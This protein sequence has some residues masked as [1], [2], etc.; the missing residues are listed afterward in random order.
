MDNGVPPTDKRSGTRAP[1]AA[2]SRAAQPA[3][4]RH[5][6]AGAKRAGGRAGAAKA[7]TSA[8]GSSSTTGNGSAGR[9][10]S[11]RGAG[12]KASSTARTRT[13]S[14]TASEPTHADAAVVLAD[15]PTLEA[16][17]MPLL[18]P[19]IVPAQPGEVAAAEQ[20][21]ESGNGRA[22]LAAWPMSPPVTDQPPVVPAGVPSNG[23]A[24][25]ADHGATARVPSVKVPSGTTTDTLP[26]LLPSPVPEFTDTDGTDGLPSL[27]KPR[28]AQRA[29]RAPVVRP[30][31]RPRVRRVTRVVRHV[32]S[33]SVFK[34]ALVFNLFLYG[35]C[36]T[37]GVMLWQVAQ[38]TGTVDNIERFFESFGWE[39][40]ELKGGEI[41]HNAWIAGLFVV[42]GLTGLAVLMATLFNL[43]TDLV[44]G[45]RVSVL[46]EEVVARDDRGMG[47]RRASRAK[48][49]EPV[50][51]AAASNPVE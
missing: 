15:L 46:E 25:H 36:L 35:V 1:G 20:R 19:P 7:A 16:S 29:L 42:V 27:L 10:Q 23:H 17:P 50:G 34:V 47:W 28:K 43:I 24:D 12:K 32:D 39:R 48:I 38:N 18:L 41:Y 30:R 44:G 2:K 14:P 3:D 13:H 5:E 49:A 33:W 22:K 4:P 8:N 31:R 26:A 6:G 21:T 51:P 11:S 9:G 45:V 40:F 37:A